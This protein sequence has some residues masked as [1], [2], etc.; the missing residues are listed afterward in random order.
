MAGSDAGLAVR[1]AGRLLPL[2][3][4][5]RDEVPARFGFEP[6]PAPAPAPSPEDDHAP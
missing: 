1:L 2:T 5:R 6:E 3:A 4:V